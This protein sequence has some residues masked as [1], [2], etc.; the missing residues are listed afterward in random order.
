MTTVKRI[1]LVEDNPDDVDLTIRAFRS[2]Q[3]NQDI[4]V[5][6]DGAAALESR[7]G[8]AA[9]PPP[10]DLPSLVLLDLKLPGVDGFTVLQRIRANAYTRFLPVVILTSSTEV[11]DLV[12][13]YRLGANSYVRKPVSY[14]DF[15]SVAQQIASYWLALNETPRPM[16]TDP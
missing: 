12:R 13:G 1:L 14:R 3:I 11:V 8:S 6:R 16:P 5:A 7:F 4:S 9:Q 15:L 10:R 2:S